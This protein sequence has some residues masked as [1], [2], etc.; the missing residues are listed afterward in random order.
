MSQDFAEVRI[1]YGAYWSTPFCRWQT[2]F[3]DLHSIRFAA[4]T[5]RKVLERKKISV[6]SID[7]AVLGTTVP[8]EKSFWGAPWL[9]SLM[10]SEHISGPTIAQACAT[11]ARCIAAAASAIQTH[12][13]AVT[14]VVTCDR[15][16]N[17]PVVTYPNPRGPGGA[18]QIENWILDNFREDPHARVAMV[19]TAENCARDWKISLSEQHELVLMRYEQYRAALADE[20]AFQRRYMTLPFEVPD[21]AFRK[22][23]GET[24][25]GDVGVF[26][27]TREALDK[28]KPVVEGGTVT[29][30]AQTHPADGNAG[31]LLVK[32]E[33]FA[34]FT[35]RP[36]IEIRILGVGQSRERKAYMPAA[37]VKA[38]RSALDMAGLD[39]T[40][41]QAIKSHNPFA[42]NDLVFSREFGV[43]PDKMN[44]YGCSLIYGHPQGSTGMR[45]VIE[46]IE[47]LVIRGG[48][49]GLFQGCA[50]GDTGMALVLEVR[51]TPRG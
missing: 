22:P 8:Q 1:P 33:R 29:Y 25:D 50:A 9:M 7:T 23:S 36:D 5:A 26:D 2:S 40:H 11:S 27:T 48:G 10:G 39:I 6:S 41:V 38:S 28:L 12:E 49:V 19:Q 30:G 14:L 3:A 34:E 32:R 4:D 17:T 46:L 13:S 35:S 44:N 47:E 31:M 51:D 37:P 20:R 15:T 42:V 24:I 45:L 21:P 43:Q 18:P 16:S